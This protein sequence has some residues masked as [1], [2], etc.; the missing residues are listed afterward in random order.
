M[1]EG[2]T[3]SITLY[4]NFEIINTTGN[5]NCLFESLISCMNDNKTFNNFESNKLKYI[6]NLREY[7]ANYLLSGNCSSVNANLYC[8]KTT[9]ENFTNKIRKNYNWGGNHEISI[10]S[11][12]YNCQIK[13]VCHEQENGTININIICNG[14]F[15]IQLYYSY[16]INYENINEHHECLIPHNKE[17]VRDYETYKQQNNKIVNDLNII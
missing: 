15:C 2:Q 13:V 9:P 3:K 17:N 14:N 6:I 5:G 1:E 10:F 16:N 12:L 8:S 11:L 7:L 4:K